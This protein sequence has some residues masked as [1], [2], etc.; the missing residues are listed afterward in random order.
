MWH[1]KEINEIEKVLGTNIEKGLCEEQVEERRK[2]YG[3]NKL[4][5]EKKES[6]I[7]KFFKQFNDFMIIILIIASI[8]S[9]IVAKLEIVFRPIP[10]LGLLIT[11]WRDTLS[12][13][14]WINL[15]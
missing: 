1:T 12:F 4:A 2:K 15:K 14:L 7:V 3:E 8:I 10:L 6:I 11:L 5:E 9:A 13:S